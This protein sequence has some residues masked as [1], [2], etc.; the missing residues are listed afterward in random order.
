MEH[1][2]RRI[3][4]LATACVAIGLAG[5]VARLA[6]H[7]PAA[8]ELPLTGVAVAI[9]FAL[10]AWA[11]ALASGDERPAVRLGL[12]RGRLAAPALVVLVAGMLVLNL[13]VDS[14]VRAFEV[15]DTGSLARF[16]RAV[17]R[18][19]GPALAAAALALALLPA[20]AEELFFR[21][22][23]QRGLASRLR[24]TW[25]VSLAAG[26]FALAHG[27]RVHAAA[28]FPLGLYLGA[29]AQLAGSTRAAILCHAAGNLA[30]VWVGATNLGPRALAPAF[31]PAAFALAVLALL[32]ARRLGGGRGSVPGGH[33]R[34]EQVPDAEEQ[35]EE[36]QP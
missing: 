15:R 5:V 28:A 17:A 1:H 14:A 2:P 16:D 10:L 22:W 36:Q 11:G 18:A 24:P 27:D 7:A 30:A 34:G 32:G 20:C 31:V 23:L 33:A 19:R 12:A 3:E 35:G 6:E 21:G 4:A 25:A 29:A 8:L 9:L 13:G 26:A